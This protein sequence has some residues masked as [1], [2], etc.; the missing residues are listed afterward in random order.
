[1]TFTQTQGDVTFVVTG[2]SN[3]GDR[4]PDERHVLVR[5]ETP[6]GQFSHGDTVLVRR[7]G[8]EFEAE[9]QHVGFSGDPG[10]M[11]VQVTNLAQ[12]FVSESLDVEAFA[13]AW[14]TWLFPA[15]D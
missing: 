3:E 1:M 5:V 12:G 4:R 13:D 15:D 11:Y 2:V 9:V 14:R 6:A 10:G 7:D 8:D